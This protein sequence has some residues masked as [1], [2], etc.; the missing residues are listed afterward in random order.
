M[1][2]KHNI[3]ASTR[4]RIAFFDYPD[5]FEDFYPHYGVDQK[6]FGTEWQ[7]TANHARIALVQREIG[8]VTWYV[9]CLKPELTITQH[10][11]VGCQ[12]RFLPSSWLHR[13]LWRLYY[14]TSI[15]W[16]WQCIY[17][18]YAVL[19]SY[20]A[21]FSWSV[22]QTL[23]RDRPDFIFAQDYCSGRFDILLLFSKIFK[24][25]L[26]SIHTGSTPDYYLGKWLKRF[27]IGRA[28][29]IF[30]SG[31]KE[32]QRLNQTYSIPVSRLGVI[33]ATVDLEA[34]KPM[35][36]DEACATAGLPAQHRYLLFMG[37]LDDGVKRISAIIDVFAHLNET[38]LHLLIAGS[39]QDEEKLKKQ[40]ARKA[41][42]R[43]HF[44]GWVG[45]THLKAALYNLSECMVLASWRE[46]FPSVIGEAFAC[47][48]PVVTS[49]VGTVADVVAE[50]KTGWL[51][52]AGADDQMMEKLAFVAKHPQKIAAMRPGIRAFAAENLSVE[53]VINSLKDGFYSLK[54]KKS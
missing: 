10:R 14:L 2:P 22:I 13:C 52:P 5:V 38:D 36:R 40:A 53:A 27:T 1:P 25:P 24:I 46:G 8:D 18:Y 3:P 49:D 28:D 20:L 48:T 50:G 41:P 21:P 37:R 12:V 33:R 45:A 32:K 30:A 29:W 4:P 39:G 54:K 42:D 19:S 23:R 51:F 31:N 11:Y 16:R 9:T 7:N 6:A 34:Y 15:S 47:G 44:M 26:L 35:P 17:K 43:V